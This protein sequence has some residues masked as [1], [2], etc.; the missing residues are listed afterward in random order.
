MELLGYVLPMT[1][2]M[3]GDPDFLSVH[4]VRL[5][6]MSGAMANGIACEKLVIAMGESGLLGSFGA[7]GLLPDR[8]EQ[9]I[10]E[11][12]LALPEG[13]YAFNLIHSPAEDAI[14][15]ATAELFIQKEVRTV[16]ASRKAEASTVRTSFWM[17][18]SATA[19]SIAS[20]E[21]L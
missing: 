20:S 3:L 12:Q 13:P 16:E 19:C 8:I 1:P 10:G 15:Q 11:I 7:A 18:S 6:Y 17:K 9:A 21:G 4:G 2:R 5:P 14:E